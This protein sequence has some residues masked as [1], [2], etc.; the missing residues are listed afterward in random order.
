MNP[1]ILTLDIESTPHLCYSWGFYD[2]NIIK[3]V[4]PS[5]VLMVGYKWLDEKKP[6]LLSLHQYEGFKKNVEDD[7]ALMKDVWKLMDEADV[8]VTQ[9]G[10][11]F[12]I[13]KLNTRFIKLG[14]PPPSPFKSVDT[15]KQ[16]SKH[17]YF[18]NNKLDNLGE[19]LGIG[20]KMQHEG[21]P[22]WEGCMAGDVKSFEKMGK[23][24]L[25]DIE[26]TEA[27]YLAERPYMSNH[28]NLNIYTDKP[29]ACPKCLSNKIQSRG[30]RT[31]KNNT[32]CRMY[33]CGDCGAPLYGERLP[34]AS[35]T[36]RT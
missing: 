14:L 10:D 6:K 33:R 13:K 8:I 29:E 18:V 20:G 23:Y 22:M 9:N 2:Q 21:F 5:Y 28:P 11:N 4:R 16:S 36:M 32:M 17:F 25:R 34:Q 31:F 3:V 24:C 27:V 7:T 15:K 26:V 12:D 19:E 1:K 30:E 35:L